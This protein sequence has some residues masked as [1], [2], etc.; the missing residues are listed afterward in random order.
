VAELALA[1]LRQ[2]HPD[3]ARGWIRQLRGATGPADAWR[4][5]HADLLEARIQLY[6]GNAGL[7]EP[8]LL[9]LLKAMERDEGRVSAA[10]EPLRRFYGEALLR[11]GRVAAAEK[12][13]RETEANQIQ[14]TNP[15]HNSVAITRI[16]LACAR[17]RQ[18]DVAAAGPVWQ[19]ASLLLDRELGSQHPFALAAASYAAL[20]DP[21]ATAERRVA[22]AA[23]LDRELGW[24]AGAAALAQLLRQAPG[25]VDWAQ[26]PVV[27]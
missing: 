26:L 27:L 21:A 4:D 16:L 12:V 23:R 20:A 3:A 10:T 22:L 7:A 13:L 5:D 17:A 19:A 1:E 14:L 6:V 24:Q 2:G 25:A 9:R 11:L 18:G 8:E 15:Q